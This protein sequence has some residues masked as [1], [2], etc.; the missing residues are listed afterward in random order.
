[1]DK[2]SIYIFVVFMVLV[3]MFSIISNILVIVSV[4]K[5]R[6]LRKTTNILIS[7]LAVSDILLAGIVIPMKLHDLWHTDN[8]H[9]G[10]L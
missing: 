3:L 9:E 6:K 2:T 7:N 10:N 8:Y 5:F 1:M 4:V